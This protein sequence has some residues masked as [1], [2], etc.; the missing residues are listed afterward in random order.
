MAGRLDARRRRH[1]RFQSWVRE[2]TLERV[3]DAL[4]QDLKDRGVELR[5][6]HIYAQ[7][8]LAHRIHAQAS[9]L[10]APA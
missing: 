2:W 7:T 3:L 10:L 8:G 1:R 6:G 9:S 5:F 4:A